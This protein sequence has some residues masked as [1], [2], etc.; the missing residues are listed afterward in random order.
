MQDPKKPMRHLRGGML[1]PFMPAL[2]YVPRAAEKLRH[3]L[4]FGREPSM[5]SRANARICGRRSIQ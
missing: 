4:F 3:V 2:Q 1:T 5:R